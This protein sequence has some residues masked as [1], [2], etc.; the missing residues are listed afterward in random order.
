MKSGL[1]SLREPLNVAGFLCIVAALQWIILVFVAQ[2]YYPGYSITK[3][4]LSDLG[5]TCHNA[6]GPTPGLCRIYQPASII[7][8]V[9]SRSMGF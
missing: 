3:N 7:W 5:A 8:N 1:M 6:V 2:T 4:D 9:T